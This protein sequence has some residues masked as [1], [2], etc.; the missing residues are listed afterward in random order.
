MRIPYMDFWRVEDGRT[1][2]NPVFVD[3]A[4]VL[5]QL[6]RDVFG[7][8]GWEAYDGGEKTPLHPE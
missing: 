7:G 6:G 5:A 1:S 4:A 2:D 8:E 3:F